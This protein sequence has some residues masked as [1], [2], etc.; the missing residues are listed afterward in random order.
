M[1]DFGQVMHLDTLDLKKNRLN[2]PV[3]FKSFFYVT[4]V[5]LIT[6]M[7]VCVSPC[8]Y[9][10]VFIYLKTPIFS[11]NENVPHILSKFSDDYPKYIDVVF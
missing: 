7:Y 2:V 11:I 10:F 1:N 6:Y 3:S 9:A 4:G 5:C 8:L